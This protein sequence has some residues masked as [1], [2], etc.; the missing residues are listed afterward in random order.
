MMSASFR[1]GA[2][3][4]EEGGAVESCASSAPAAMTDDVR[5]CMIPLFRDV[6][7]GSTLMT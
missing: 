7:D 2:V 4:C 3:D 1:Q 6:C 5:G